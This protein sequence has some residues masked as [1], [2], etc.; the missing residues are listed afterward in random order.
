MP[1]FDALRDALG[2]E[3]PEALLRLALTHPS[4]TE[5]ARRTQESYQRLEFLGDAIVGAIV[6]AH[7]YQAHPDRPEGELTARKIALVRR[8]TLARAAKR[9]NLGRYLVLGA[10]EEK[11]GGRERDKILSDAFEA[12]LGALFLT[13]GWEAAQRWTLSMLRDELEIGDDISPKNLLQERTQAIGLGTPVYRSAPTNARKASPTFAAEV[14]L[15]D[16]VHGR[17][18]GRTKQEAETAAAQAALDAMK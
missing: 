2:C 7:L 18:T 9:A 10:G 12:V 1:E 15:L 8:E 4:A 14:L 11:S 13:G 17:G 16:E 6:A 5:S 3:V